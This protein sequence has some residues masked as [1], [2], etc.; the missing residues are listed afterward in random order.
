MFNKEEILGIPE[1]FCIKNSKL[2]LYPSPAEKLIVTIDYLTL[3]VGVNKDDEEIFY[4]END[5]DV[6]MIPEYLEEIFKNAVISR[7]MLNS[8][9][10]ECDENYSA[11]KKQSETAYRQLVKYSKGVG[12]EKKIV[13]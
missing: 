5:D 13:V 10:S 11:Y 8:I 9:A 12:Q 2:F 1:Y 4:L 3:A 7:T 6:I